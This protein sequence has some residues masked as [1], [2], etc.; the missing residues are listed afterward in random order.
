MRRKSESV[1]PLV[2]LTPSQWDDEPIQRSRTMLAG[3][4]GV[5]GLS[6]EFVARRRELRFYLRPATQIALDAAVGQLRAAYPQAGLRILN[7]E[8]RPYVDPAWRAPGE[9][10][11]ALRLGLARDS[12]Y[13][14][15]TGV[16]S[17]D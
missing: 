16:R 6:L 10:S 7:L 15:F 11:A 3:L 12:A 4:A 2:E 9:I 13:P 8:E 17:S 5:D 1:L 14:L